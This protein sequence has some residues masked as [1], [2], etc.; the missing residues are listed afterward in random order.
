MN[1][2][3]PQCGNPNL[4]VDAQTNTVFCQQCGFAVQV[5]PTTGNVTPISQGSGAPM[6]G[7]AG[8]GAPQGQ[9]YGPA[10]ASYGGSS[11]EGRILGMNSLTFFLFFTVV[12]FMA[13]LVGLFDITIVFIVE[14]LLFIV[15]WYNH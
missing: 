4:Q 2:N 14:I 5:D 10:P 12:V 3:C 9:G 7:G 13:W 8:M 6:G 11:H 1:V 15:Y